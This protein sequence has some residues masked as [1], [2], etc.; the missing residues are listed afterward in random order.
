MIVAYAFDRVAPIMNFY[1]LRT[2]ELK[3]YARCVSD[4]SAC[5][6]VDT[7]FCYGNDFSL[8]P[9][10]YEELKCDIDVPF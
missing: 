3:F 1:V 5:G 4:Q 10:A 6:I 2:I 9:R 7:N 8:T